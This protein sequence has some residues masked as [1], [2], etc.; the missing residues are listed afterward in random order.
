MLTQIKIINY[1]PI[2][3]MCLYSKYGLHVNE[4]QWRD[5]KQKLKHPHN[6]TPVQA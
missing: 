5:E 1:K 3:F 4:I 2:V 6:I